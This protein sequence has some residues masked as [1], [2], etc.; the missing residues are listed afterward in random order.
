LND[1]EFIKSVH[2]SPKIFL[3][4]SDTTVNHLMFYKLGLS[5]YYG[6]SFLSDLAELGKNMLP[7]SQKWF[8]TLLG[9]E[10]HHLEISPQWYLE[11]TSFDASQVGVEHESRPEQHGFEFLNG[12]GTVQGQLLGGCLESFYDLKTGNHHQAEKS[13]SQKYQIFP[14]R[15][16]WRGKILFIETS[17]EHPTPE[18]YTAML[19][20]LENE[21]VFDEIAGL[22]HGKPQDEIYYDEYKKIL[23]DMLQKHSLTA[24][25][26]LNFGHAFPHLIFR[27]GQ[28]I[29][30]DFDNKKIALK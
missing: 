15:E 29:T 19:K 20:V 5:T 22:V 9:D 18:K 13:V 27:Y 4:Y 25:Y 8:K 21:G 30:L 16:E 24:V 12:G 7:Y 2:D 17:E 11:R 1:E 6:Q 10:I 28:T 3:G 23:S 26:N 14:G